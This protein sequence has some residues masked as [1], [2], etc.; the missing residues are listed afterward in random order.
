V[1]DSNQTDTATPTPGAADPARQVAAA[2]DGI[3]GV[4]DGPLDDAVIRLDALHREL[5]AALADLDQN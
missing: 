2:S 5:Q 1:T 3:A 4:G